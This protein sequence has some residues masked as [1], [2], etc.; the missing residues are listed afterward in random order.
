MCAN[1]LRRVLSGLRSCGFGSVS[2]DQ[3][4]MRFRSRE[5]DFC[6]CRL[7]RADAIMVLKGKPYVHLGAANCPAS[8]PIRNGKTCSESGLEKTRQEPG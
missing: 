4:P 5:M 2:H 3:G 6:H 7:I 8:I 1:I